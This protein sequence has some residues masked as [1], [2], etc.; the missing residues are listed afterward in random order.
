MH[1]PSSGLKGASETLR[2]APAMKQTLTLR[3]L[4]PGTA[5]AQ[6]DKPEPRAER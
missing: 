6:P 5:T 4:G 2:K 3:H 1:E